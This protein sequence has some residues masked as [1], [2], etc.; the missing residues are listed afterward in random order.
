MIRLDTNEVLA[1][2]EGNRAALE[3]VLRAAERPIH[4][5]AMRMLAHPADAQDATQEILIRI[6][7]HLGSLRDP[8]AAG[9]WAMRIATR[10]LVQE[11]KRGRI[12]ATRLTFEGFAA[13]LEQGRKT[14]QDD[15]L[16]DAETALAIE[17]VKIGCTLA[18]LVC[19]SRQLRIAYILSEIFE[20]SDNEA[21]SI[22]EI[23]PAA[24][25]KRLHRARASVIEFTRSTCGV[26]SASAACACD[27][28]V[29]A[30]MRQGRIAKGKSV[31]GLEGRKPDDVS[32]LRQNVRSLEEGRNAA[33]LMRSNPSF[34]TD[35]KSLVLRLV[36]RGETR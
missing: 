30:A 28:R 33:A 9:A 13:D 6:L 21:S 20:L 35:V 19:L 34:P 2:R 17:E 31:F 5:L 12:E 29:D 26:V 32:T 36:D 10:Y 11:R 23:A 16:T 4:D 14:L 24:Y 15:R 1:A 3:A 25:R 27:S 7:T 22:L 18:M 8:E